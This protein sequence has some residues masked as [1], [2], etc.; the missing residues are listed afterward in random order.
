[1]VRLRYDP[2]MRWIKTRM[3]RNQNVIIIINGGTGS[4]KT[5]GGITL[6]IDVAE[7]MG[8]NFT[9]KSNMD[10]NFVELLKKM[11]LPENQKV[12]TPFLFEEVGAVGG[13]AASREWQSQA[14]RFFQSFMQTSRHRNQILIM[15]CPNFSFLEKGARE[16]VHMQMEMRSINYRKKVSCAR[17]YI[18]QVN[19]KTGKIYFKYLRFTYKENKYKFNNIEFNM[20]PKDVIDEYEVIKRLYTDKL[21]KSIIEANKEK[22]KCPKQKVPDEE[23]RRAL[24]KGLTSE[25]AARMLGISERTVTRFR[26]RRKIAL[27]QTKS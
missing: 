20:P 12:G 26:A 13:G 27:K 5:Y 10:F 24:D 7:M 21:N 22:V 8:S 4:G 25:Q 19:R 14:N 16:L 3:D 15:T 23:M 6:S 17:P 2:A 11:D 9:I 1:M 18:L